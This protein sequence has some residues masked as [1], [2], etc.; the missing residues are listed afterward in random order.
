[1]QGI[2]LSRRY[3]EE[4]GVPMIKNGFSDIEDQ[5]ACGIVGEGSECLGC[6]DEISR[7]HDFAPGFTVWISRE[8]DEKYGFRL[9]RAYESLPKVFM[10]VKLEERS[11]LGHTKFGV[12]IIPDFYASLTGLDRMPESAEEWFSIPDYALCCATNGEVF[13][14]PCGEFS[15]WREHLRY[16]PENVRLKKLAAHLA[17]CAQSGQYAYP[18]LLA[19]GEATAARLCAAEFANHAIAAVF[20][21]KRA[22]M[23]YYKWRMRL[24]R[25]LPLLGKNVAEK[26]DRLFLPDGNIGTLIESICTDIAAECVREGLSSSADDYLENHAISVTSGITDRRIRAL[27]L[28]YF[29]A[30]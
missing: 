9:M 19:H 26:I 18:R 7:D 25:S 24:M 20:L 28:M 23:P 11:Y 29:G 3:F 10:G 2:E 12:K 22:H 14:D 30:Q 16:L 15:A 5:L 21:L 1:M 27:H 4:Y 13:T 8:T 6:D 17:L